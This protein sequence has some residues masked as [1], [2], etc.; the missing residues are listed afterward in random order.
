[1]IVAFG[2]LGEAGGAGAG[3]D[4]G[5]SCGGDEAATI[6]V[7]AQGGS[8]AEFGGSVTPDRVRR[9]RSKRGLWAD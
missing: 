4:G 2:G 8:V 3:G 1:M 6:D 5:E 7:S 9:G